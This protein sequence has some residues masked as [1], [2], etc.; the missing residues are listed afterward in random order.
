MTAI[1]T[2]PLNDADR[3]AIDRFIEQAWSEYGLAENTLASYRSD[4]TGFARWLGG[5][6]NSLASASRELLY[7]YL[8]V[9]AAAKYTARSNARLLSTLR[10]YYKLMRR[11]GAVEQDPTLLLDAPKL[12]RSLPKALSESEV[13]GLIRA[14]DV[15]APRGL[16]DRAML[17]LLYATGL[18]VSELVSLR[19]D[20]I[21]L[22]QG[23]LRVTGKGGK[24]RL[25]PLGEEAQ[26][27]L[28]RYV[29]QARPALMRGRITDAIFVTA[30][31]AG[32]TR[33][34][35]WVMVKK[36]GQSAGIAS[37][38]ISPHVLRHSFATHLLNHGADL[39][40][41]QLLLGHSSLST[42]QI[43]THVAREGLKRLHAQ[44]HPR[45]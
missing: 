41:L 29:A 37:Q 6:G 4:L 32:M 7:R 27:W 20:Q 44:H 31:A 9:R 23:V 14:P 12:P 40:A 2:P 16:R 17:E 18:R 30:R 42:T 11:I 38:R 10:R 35:F 34:M 25:V 15:T 19:A 33:Q 22:R 28:E 21:N 1:E 26:D 45:G 43:Y 5:H 8:A 39:R 36:H 24:D 13:V 3:A